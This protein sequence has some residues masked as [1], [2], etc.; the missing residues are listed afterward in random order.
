MIFIINRLTLLGYV[1]GLMFY[2]CAHDT[3]YYCR[4]MDECICLSYL[5]AN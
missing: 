4:D 1:L 3:L 5:L 2:V